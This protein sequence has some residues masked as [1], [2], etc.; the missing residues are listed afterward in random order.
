M[1]NQDE[2]HFFGLVFVANGVHP[3]PARIDDIRSTTKP[4]DADELREFLEIATYMSP[5]IPKLSE[6]SDPP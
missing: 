2:L 5:F 4:A 3:D 6:H 1:Q